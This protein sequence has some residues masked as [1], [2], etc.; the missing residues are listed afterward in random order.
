MAKFFLK[1]ACKHLLPGQISQFQLFPVPLVDQVVAVQH[2]LRRL[3]TKIADGL[4]QRDPF[5]L[6]KIQDGI[7]QIQQQN[8]IHSLSS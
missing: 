1:P 4:S 5:C 2:F 6:V 7:I 8:L 3:Y